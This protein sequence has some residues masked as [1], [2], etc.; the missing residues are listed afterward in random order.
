MKNFD[1]IIVGGGIAGISL[2]E[3]L[4]REGHSV[5]LIEKNK[6]LASEAT[7]EFHEWVHT[8]SLYTLVKDKMKTLKY[9]LGSLDDLLEFYSSFPKM[10]LKPTERG[11]KILNEENGWFNSNYINFKYRLKN[12]KFIISWLY[13]VSRSMALI[14]GISKHDWL[15]R[16]AG[17]LE[18]VTGKYYIPILKNFIKVLFYK[19]KFLKIQTTDFT[20][21]SR[22]LLEDM[23][24][25]AVNN[26]L[27][28]YTDT[29][30]LQINNS[31]DSVMA[32]CKNETFQGK[33]MVVCL[34]SEIEKFSD[35]KLKKNFAPI[36]VVKNIKSNTE[37]FVELDYFKK[38]CINIITKNKSYGLVGGISLKDEKE[39][40]NYFNFMINQHKE[41]NPGIEVIKKYVGM[42]NE[43]SMNNENRNYLFHINRASKYNNVWSIIPGK[44]TLAFSLA[45]EFYRIIYKKNPKKIFK[46]HEGK[47]KFS[48]LIAKTV[49][50]DLQN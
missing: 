48:H 7:R 6:K 12:R 22:Y 4:T 5:A 1:W 20:T 41:Q 45:P 23:V 35:F 30:L 14:D 38:N 26:G 24:A 39:T 47:G 32:I 27:E 42:K 50:E 46:T 29:E 13:S 31:S 16:R 37:S 44:F 18:S 11:L 17:I 49:W 21:N 3:I 43:V 34:G 33:N 19:N 2:S 25:T 9:V 28:I 40:E 36:A 15:R 8:G 10:N